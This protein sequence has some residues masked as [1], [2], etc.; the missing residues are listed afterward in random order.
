MTDTSIYNFPSRSKSRK[1]IINEY[2]KTYNSFTYEDLVAFLKYCI[3]GEKQDAVKREL[4][5]MTGKLIPSNKV[6]DIMGFLTVEVYQNQLR[7]DELETYRNL[8]IEKVLEDVEQYILAQIEGREITGVDKKIARLYSSSSEE[9][10]KKNAEKILQEMIQE[11]CIKDGDNT[12]C[13][14][15]I[16]KYLDMCGVEDEETKE[17]LTRHAILTLYEMVEKG[18]KVLLVEKIPHTIMREQIGDT[19][20]ESKYLPKENIVIETEKELFLTVRYTDTH[21]Y[22]FEIEE[23]TKKTYLRADDGVKTGEDILPPNRIRIFEISDLW[24]EFDVFTEQSRYVFKNIRY[25]VGNKGANEKEVQTDTIHDIVNYISSDA[26][27]LIK[28]LDYDITDEIINIVKLICQHRRKYKTSVYGIIDRDK[29][30][31]PGRYELITEYK[32]EKIKAYESMF[33]GEIQFEKLPSIAQNLMKYVENDYV[34]KIILQYSIASIFRYYLLNT[35]RIDLFP[36]LIVIGEKGRGKSARIN[37]LFNQ[38]LMG[39]VEYY[40]KDYLKGSGIRLQNEG[41]TTMPMF[42]DELSEIPSSQYDILKAIATSPKAT[43]TKYT[44]QQKRITYTIL[45]PLII[46]TNKV[47]ITDEAFEDRCIIVPV[48][49]KICGEFSGKEEIYNML[50]DCIEELGKALYLKI[51]RMLEII[52]EINLQSRRSTAKQEVIRL[53]G[54]L[55][56]RIFKEEFGIDYEPVSLKTFEEDFT[57]SS[58]DLIEEHI[59]T[60]V[61]RLIKEIDPKLSLSDLMDYKIVEDDND[62]YPVDKAKTRLLRM[63]IYVKYSE[64]EGKHYIGISKEGMKYLGLKSKFGIKSLRQLASELNTIPSTMRDGN[65]HIKVVKIYLD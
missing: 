12:V 47:T 18:V 3:K 55:I 29:K 57:V 25:Y 27:K 31:L 21:K 20:K 64:K 11:C 16:Q 14:F 45:R 62:D 61:R 23:R 38:L 56:K 48:D 49:D 30:F 50:R 17:E 52:D 60:E 39:T 36:N 33:Q 40:T 9:D 22:V 63:G 4:I 1:D 19:Y 65:S 37:L 59:I 28:K 5:D 15:S 54:E 2:L 41:W 32:D 26:I 53:G 44:S 8:N 6:Y 13:I 10:M 51:D 35:K 7:F 58:K 34:S 42:I 43:V 46:A 24:E